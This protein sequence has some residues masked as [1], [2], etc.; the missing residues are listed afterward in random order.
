MSDLKQ[1]IAIIKPFREDFLTNPDDEE[2]A[3]MSQHFEY[4]QNLMK[5][6]LILLAGPTTNEKNPFGIIILNVNSKNKAEK[7][8]RNDPS[9]RLQIQKLIELEPFRVSL[10]NQNS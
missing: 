8:I 9:I 3:I 6:G 10:L 4:L 7:L 5:K 1:F 2:M